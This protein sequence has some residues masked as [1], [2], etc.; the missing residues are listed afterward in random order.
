VRL[1]RVAKPGQAFG[2]MEAKYIRIGCSYDGFSLSFFLFFFFFFSM[3]LE[4]P[5]FHVSLITVLEFKNISLVD[6][7]F[8]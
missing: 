5:Y 7:L 8:P 1:K 3:W 4:M 6:L 2:Y